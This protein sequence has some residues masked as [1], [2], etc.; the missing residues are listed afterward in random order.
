MVGGVHSGPVSA[1]RYVG[2]V[3]WLLFSGVMI[4]MAREAWRLIGRAKRTA[5]FPTSLF[6]G[7]PLIWEPF[8]YTLVF[9]GFDGAMP[10][11]V[12]NLGMLK[13]LKNSLDAHDARVGQESALAPSAGPV[14]APVR[15]PPAPVV[16]ALR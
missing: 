14:L 7:V 16:G 11:A 13:M 8:H 1:I 6:I 4:L 15:R 5:F 12:F 3:G 10:A 9:G 2:V